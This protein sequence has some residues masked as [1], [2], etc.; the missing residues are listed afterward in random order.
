MKAQKIDTWI[1]YN[2]VLKE[3]PSEIV[4]TI[5][6]LLENKTIYEPYMLISNVVELVEA[7]IFV[8]LELKNRDP[9]IGVYI[10]IFEGVYAWISNSNKLNDNLQTYKFEQLDG[11]IRETIMSGV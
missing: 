1:I 10:S 5:I 4:R 11:R 2:G 3:Q 7:I 6:G 9:D 8:G